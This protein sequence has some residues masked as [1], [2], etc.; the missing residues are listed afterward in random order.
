MF[1]FFMDKKKIYIKSRKWNKIRYEILLYEGDLN[2]S[3][4]LL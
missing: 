4:Y 2:E 1:F 3:V